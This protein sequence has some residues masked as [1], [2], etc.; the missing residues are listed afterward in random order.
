MHLGQPWKSTKEEVHLG[1]P[2]KSNDSMSQRLCE[3]G[4]NKAMHR[5]DELYEKPVTLLM[6]RTV[7]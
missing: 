7:F 3:L 2:W 6:T 5:G 1:Q 4:Q